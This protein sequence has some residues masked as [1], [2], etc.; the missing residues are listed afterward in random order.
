MTTATAA[1]AVPWSRQSAGHARNSALSPPAGPTV[2]P[3]ARNEP[4]AAR[5]E[6]PAA[7]TVAPAARI[8]APP[9]CQ[10]R[11]QPGQPGPGLK[12][13]S[14]IYLSSILV[15]SIKIDLA[16]ACG[17]R[18]QSQPQI[19]TRCV[20]GPDQDLAEA[21][22]ARDS[23]FVGTRCDPVLRDRSI[24]TAPTPAYGGGGATERSAERQQASRPAR[25][26][27]RPAA[28]RP[29]KRP[30]HVPRGWHGRD[31]VQDSARRAMAA[32]SPW[33]VPDLPGRSNARSAGYGC[34][35]L[36]RR[37]RSPDR[38]GRAPAVWHPAR[39]NRHR[40]CAGAS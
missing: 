3:A 25:Q 19:H 32:T 38:A 2:A 29:V 28:R 20:T 14:E 16:N 4:P 5:A 22:S 36:R 18:A 1:G 35:A 37:P 34:V 26:V 8:E 10:P 30:G 21:R 9:P 31:Q 24:R 40:R 11:P 33:R 7:R 15:T 27:A 39:S 12:N 17:S 13:S 23:R 6:A